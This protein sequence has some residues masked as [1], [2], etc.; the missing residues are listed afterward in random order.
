MIIHISDFCRRQLLNRL[1][2]FKDKNE[3]P[4]ISQVKQYCGIILESLTAKGNTRSQNIYVCKK[5][6]ILRQHQ[7]FSINYFQLDLKVDGENFLWSVLS[8][9]Q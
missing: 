8:I 6:Y 9:N 1:R 4:A 5:Y 2:L 7:S 3:F